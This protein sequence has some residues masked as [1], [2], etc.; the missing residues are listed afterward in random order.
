[1]LEESGAFDVS[2]VYSV[3]SE[4]APE[5][6]VSVAGGSYVAVDVLAEYHLCA[7]G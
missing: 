1:M 4:C 7:G 3:W 2:I 5:W 6:V